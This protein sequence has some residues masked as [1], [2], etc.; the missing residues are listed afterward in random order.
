MDTVDK[1]DPIDFE[2]IFE[3]IEWS[4][5]SISRCTKLFETSQYALDVVFGVNKNERVMF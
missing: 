3:N 2:G 1:E 5:A 4:E